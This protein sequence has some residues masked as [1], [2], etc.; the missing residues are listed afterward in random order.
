MHSKTTDEQKLQIGIEYQEGLTAKELAAIYN[1]SSTVIYRIL[2]QLDIPRRTGGHQ[3]PV[4]NDS[5]F[6]K[7]NT[8]KKAYFLGLL[9]ADG[10]V[11]QPSRSGQKLFQLELLQQDNYLIKELCKELK[12]PIDRI[13]TYKRADKSATSKVSIISNRLAASLK[14]YGIIADKA[15]WTKLP[16]VTTNLT[17]HVLRGLY[18]GDGSIAKYRL[19]LTA[20][21]T[22]ILN[23]VKNHLVQTLSLNPEA[24]KIYHTAER[25]WSLSINRKLERASVMKYLYE[26]AS[27]KMIRKA[28]WLGNQPEQT[29]RELLETPE[30]DNQQPSLESDLSEGSTTS[31]N[32]V[33][34]TMKDHERGAPFQINQRVKY[35]GSNT[36]YNDMI[37]RVTYLIPGTNLVKVMFELIQLETLRC[38]YSELERVMI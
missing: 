36:R 11:C 21:N 32:S 27:V 34:D 19:V 12:Y 3:P 1:C 23:Q 18:D 26:N 14:P 7:I 33:S 16:A 4:F 9:I 10:S 20:G 24:I 38:T 31:S 35:L 6:D 28:R 2:K 17:R 5:Y 15:P 25:A 29:P 37:G 22:V 8:E 13:K 30:E